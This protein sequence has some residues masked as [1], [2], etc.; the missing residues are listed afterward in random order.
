MNKGIR[1]T[2]SLC[3]LLGCLFGTVSVAGAQTAAPDAAA[4]KPAE[5]ATAK[6]AAKPHKMAP[7]AGAAVAVVTV[8]NKRAVALTALDATPSGG[9]EAVTILKSLA[10]GKKATAKVKHGKDCVFD[11]HGA[12]EDGSSTDMPGVDLCKEKSF[13]L[14]E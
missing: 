8:T 13:N 3:A 10:P 11:L 4:A 2:I 9:V 14:V 7:K 6:P 1:N 5:D 12:Y